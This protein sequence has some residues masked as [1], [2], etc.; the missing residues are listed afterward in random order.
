MKTDEL[1]IGTIRCRV[2][3]DEVYTN[4]DDLIIAI[5]YQISNLHDKYKDAPGFDPEHA[6][7]INGT[8]DLICDGIS[9]LAIEAIK[10]G[11]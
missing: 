10:Q 6:K 3:D 9:N 11:K 8:V 5:Q 2:I 4:V 7:T 1:V